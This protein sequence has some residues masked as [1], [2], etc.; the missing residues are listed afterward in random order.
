[1][2]PVKPDAPAE[3][4]VASSGFEAAPGLY[5][6]GIALHHAIAVGA[7]IALNETDTVD[8][9]RD[10]REAAVGTDE[11]H[12]GLARLGRRRC[13]LVARHPLLAPSI[14]RLARLVTH[15]ALDGSASVAV[16]RAVGADDAFAL[17]PAVNVGIWASMEVISLAHGAYPTRPNTGSPK[18][19]RWSGYTRSC[20]RC[21]SR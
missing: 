8:A 11:L 5:A 10:E 7:A 14:D 9:G 16:K 13:R 4:R 2:A 18:P 15:A 1:M 21:R 3:H 12:G 20:R 17:F 6:R 19:K